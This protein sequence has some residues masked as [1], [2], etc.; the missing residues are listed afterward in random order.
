LSFMHGDN[1]FKILNIVLIWFGINLIM[2]GTQNM[3]NSGY[4]P[5]S[6]PSGWIMGMFWIIGGCVVSSCWL[7][8]ISGHLIE[9]KCFNKPRW[10]VSKILTTA[11]FLILAAGLGI[12]GIFLTW[13]HPFRL[14]PCDCLDNEFGPL[15]MPCKCTEHGLCDA[16]EYGSGR[17]ACDLGWAGDYCEICDDRWK[18]EGQCDLCKTGYEGEKCQ[19]CTVGYTGEEC[20]IC[21]DGWRK[22]Q[23]FSE[24]FPN[25]ISDDDERHLCDECLPNHYGYNC[26][27]CPY[28]H[29]VP[30]ITLDRN[31]PIIFG[32]RVADDSSKAGTVQDMEVRKNGEWISSYDYE[33]QNPQVLDDTRIKIKYDED[34]IIS[35]WLT[36]GEIKGVQCNNRGTCVDDVKHLK[37]N[38]DWQDTCTYDFYQACSSNKDCLVSQNCKGFCKGI[39][40]PINSLWSAKF[41]NN[42]CETDADCI[43]RSLYINELNETYEGGRCVTRGCCDESFHGDGTCECDAQFFG[44]YESGPDAPTPQYKKSPGCDFCPGYDWITEEFTTICSGKGTC[45]ASYGRDGKYIGMRC[46]CGE[47]AFVDPE[48]KIVDENKN[49]LWSGDLC[50]CGDFEFFGSSDGKCDTCVSGYWGETCSQCPGGAQQRQ[51]SGHGICDDGVFGTGQCTCKID[52]ASSWMLAPYVKRYPSEIVGLNNKKDDSTCS[53]CAPNFWGEQCLRC[54]DT[55]QIK[56]DQFD[57]IFQPVGSF[58][59]GQGQSSATP[60]PL[61][62]PQQPWICSFACGRGGWCNWGRQGDGSCMCWQNKRLNDH[63]WNP[64]DNVCIGNDRYE[65]GEFDGTQEKCSTYGYCSEGTRDRDTEDTC[66]SDDDW[67]DNQKDME[68]Q[69]IGWQAYDDWKTRN[70]NLDCNGNDNV[71]YKW[72]PITFRDKYGITCEMEG[73]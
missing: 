33:T 39:E 61:C 9:Q 2:T 28:G 7:T 71:C 63:T 25:V 8:Y 27:Q 69:G 35:D 51:C 42:L 56:P 53:E 26:Q 37:D 55:A 50:Q 47:E 41:D 36:F 48:T 22:W 45:G 24:L 60:Q 32:T 38:P 16:G 64:L 70:Y 65:T 58:H 67:L 29:D 43:D 13:R 18:P 59:F 6:M 3:Y 21:D 34:N 62:H 52:R 11:I 31:R 20:D 44:P 5:P 23:N 1:I 46:T 73:A 40:L 12:T 14:G 30:H 10:S 72:L 15:C 17:C 4:T 57:D 66:G 19:Y 49:I 54:S 68:I